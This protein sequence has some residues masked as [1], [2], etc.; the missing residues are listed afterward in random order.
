MRLS[1]FVEQ[2]KASGGE[3]EQPKA[4]R[5]GDFVSL[6]REENAVLSEGV[7]EIPDEKR[8]A[9]EAQGKIGFMEQL[10]RQD[11]TEMIPFNPEGAVK[12]INLLRATNRLRDPQTLPAQKAQDEAL[13]SAYLE[14]VEEERVRGFSVGGRVVQGV[15]QLPAY[16]FEFLATEGMAT[17]GRYALK[18]SLSGATRKIVQSGV[19][20]ATTRA[21][22][23]IAGATVRT[24]GMPHRLAQA[25]AD[26]QLNAGLELTE[27][28]V[29]LA[30]EI[31][32]KPHTSAMKALGDVLIENLSETTGPALRKGAGY[33]IPREFKAG[34]ERLF[35]RIRP[36]EPVRNLWTK[37]GYHGFLEELGE[38]RVGNFLKALTGVEDFGADDP[39]R[40]WDR[41][42]A[43][44]PNG[45]EL[46]VEALVL[47]VPGSLRMGTSQVVDMV[48]RRK[49]EAGA[50]EPELQELA[51]EQLAEIA[52]PPQAAQAA[53]A[54]ISH[55]G[56]VPLA[57][58]HQDDEPAAEDGLSPDLTTRL[59]EDGVDLTAL[60]SALGTYQEA[61]T[62]GQAPS[63]ETLQAAL[64]GHGITL[65]EGS[66]A[67]LGQELAPPGS[68]APEAATSGTPEG[69]DGA[70][71]G[72]SKEIASEK[73]GRGR[74]LTPAERLAYPDL[75]EVESNLAAVRLRIA[76]A[77]ERGVEV[78]ASLTATEGALL[79][80]VGFE[81]GQTASRTSPVKTTIRELTGQT[82]RAES[83]VSAFQALKESL[84]AQAQAASAAARMTRE[85][86]A[87]AQTQLIE[88]LEGSE[89][90]ADDKAKFLRAL[91]NIQSQ[92]HLGGALPEIEA[93][94]ESLLERAAKRKTLLAIHSELKKVLPRRQTG[95]LVG[96]FTPLVQEALSRMRRASRLTQEE[97]A[98]LLEANL[99]RHSSG[100]A[101][102]PDAATALENKMLNA[103]AHRED[104]SSDELGEL[105]NTVRAL[106]QGGKA[107]AALKHVHEQADLEEKRRIA[108]GIIDSRPADRVKTTG[109]ESADDTNWGW[110]NRA[111]AW[112]LGWQNIMNRLSRADKATKTDES[113]LSRIADVSDAETAEKRG[114]RR[115]LKAVRKMW[116]D[117][118]GEASDWQLMKRWA[119]ESERQL[120][121]QFTNARGEQ[122]RVEMSKAEARKRWMEFQD[123]TLQETFFSPDGMAW[124]EEMRRAVEN[125]LSPQDITFARDQMDFY[126]DYYK[127]FNEV[128]SDING[129]NL[130]RNPAYSPIRREFLER[131]VLENELL[132]EISHRRSI[133]PTPGKTRAKNIR[134]L[135]QLNDVEIIQL[136][137]HQV[138][139][140][141]AWARKIRVLN[142]IFND[143][144]VR[145]AI[146]GNFG[147]PL[148]RVID[149]GIEDF[150]RGGIDR[151]SD[152]AFLNLIKN[153]YTVSVLA[154]K[155]AITVKQLMS[156]PAFADSIP[157]KDFMAGLADLANEPGKKMQILASSEVMRS[158]GL[159]ITPEMAEATK[160]KDWAAFQLNPSLRNL[161]LTLVQWGD[162]GAI[163]LGG[164]P[165]YRYHREVLGKPHS[166][167]IRAFEKAL[168][169]SQQSS[170]L[171]Q[172]SLFARGNSWQ[173]LFSVFLSA[174]NQ[175]FR[176]ELMA[177]ED[178]LAGRIGKE[179]WAKVMVLYH[180]ILPMMFQWASDGLEWRTKEQ[181]RSGL[182]GSLNG[183][184]V[185]GNIAQGMV[186]QA[187]GLGSW[188]SST[189]IDSIV[190][191]ALGAIRSLDVDELDA[192]AFFGMLR[193]SGE[194]AGLIKGLPAQQAINVAEGF[195]QMSEATTGEEWR[196]GFKRVAG[197]SKHVVE[198]GGSRRRGP[199]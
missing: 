126:R 198:A 172:T 166:E 20:K 165:V 14:G 71:L 94:V 11:K 44:I 42:V 183:V 195:K 41:I 134:A 145:E 161:L 171:S 47:G 152:N 30:E 5:L 175:Y 98:A 6:G 84:R 132:G 176:K 103:V 32:E 2:S 99:G 81:P 131:A 105:L 125:S 130:P 108:K 33:L 43:S 109:D 64:S 140:Y 55:G 111:T 169:S 97:A 3:V 77:V 154:G 16:M 167:A 163:F 59:E 86:I 29:S 18:K 95:R 122:V 79:R 54:E 49:A 188:H 62:S 63:S 143:A 190:R 149:R 75:A 157:V 22:G 72:P 110:Y 142:G 69:Q 15:A 159:S 26:R 92:E 45:E 34:L 82:R 90:E 60:E 38:E 189:I 91:K 89:L 124:T 119:K 181:I 196:K 139:H 12:S 151:S 106:K 184:F 93:R 191:E 104:L 66:M 51:D 9:W 52:Q 113:Q 155:P 160:A 67:A 10:R 74:R 23:G 50:V 78:P 186:S 158:R 100:N 58:A 179:Q 197:W 46:L 40:A 61:V 117:A 87:T 27:K 180:F 1:E 147:K 53:P 36:N 199:F 138:E 121:G 83:M 39:E 24:A 37:A 31:R 137:I 187:L 178:M 56:E 28:G 70:D 193:Q 19:L 73:V 68:A 85:E 8:A 4:L 150:T 141:K 164:W 35:A 80:S 177:T 133:T 156:F 107:L 101:V 115:G 76:E 127:G 146:Q 120:L 21:A 123:P 153:N 88:L 118:F 136:H 102:I 96:R 135:R 25:Y 128:Y 148:L 162:R 114:M 65:P 192:E 7:L 129:V 170:D 48:R 168:S 13:L 112:L 173:R 144:E 194:L 185:L 17:A 57:L 182:L 116:V 174:P